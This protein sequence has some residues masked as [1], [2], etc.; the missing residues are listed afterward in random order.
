[1]KRIWWLH[2]DG[3][4]GFRS[5]DYEPS[6]FVLPNQYLPYNDKPRI[7]HLRSKA[8]EGKENVRKQFAQLLKEEKN[9]K[10]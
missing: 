10:A 9:G 2:P 6:E 3:K 7:L 5:I 1:M 8:R 4:K